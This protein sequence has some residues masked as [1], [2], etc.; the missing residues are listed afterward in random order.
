M[1]SRRPARLFLR[2]GESGSRSNAS[3]TATVRRTIREPKL[4][5]VVEW[6]DGW[7]DDLSSIRHIAD[8]PANARRYV[9]ALGEHL[10]VPIEAVSLGPERASL[11]T[12]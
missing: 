6:Y 10:R 5:T 8:L 12:A 1:R 2:P 3:A 7:D 11:A 4:E 9:A